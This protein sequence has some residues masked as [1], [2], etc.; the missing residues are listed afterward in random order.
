LI[1]EETQMEFTHHA[2]QRAQQRSV[3]HAI[4]AW[5]QEYGAVEY[6]NDARKRF[7][8]KRS[9]E[10]LGNALGHEVVKR[11]GNLLNCYLVESE[12]GRIIT[13]AHRT[14]RIRRR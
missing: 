4:V 10:R 14:E 3:P 7:F 5:L 11:L 8:D 6:S 12:D 9:R 2:T 13:V 1:E